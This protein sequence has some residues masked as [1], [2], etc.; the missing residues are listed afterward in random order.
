MNIVVYLKS[1][2]DEGNSTFERVH[3][4]VIDAHN[5]L[6]ALEKPVVCKQHENVIL[7]LL[8]KCVKGAGS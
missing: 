7:D 2:I 3:K 6:G 4:Q 5:I 1:T 8:M